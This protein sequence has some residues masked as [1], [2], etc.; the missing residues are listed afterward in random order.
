M[1]L[2]S[3]TVGSSDVMFLR[4]KFMDGKDRWIYVSLM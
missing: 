3:G 4:G 1:G 2:H